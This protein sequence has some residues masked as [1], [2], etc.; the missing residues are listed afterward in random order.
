MLVVHLF[1]YNQ[2]FWSIVLC[3][4]HLGCAFF[5]Y[6]VIKPYFIF[7]TP[8]VPDAPKGKQGEQL[9]ILVFN[10]LLSNTN[11]EA[12]IELVSNDRPDTILL[13]EPGKAWDDNLSVVYREYPH[14]IKKIQ[15]DTYG[16]IF[17]SRIPFDESK[18]NH[19]VTERTPSTE[20]LIKMGDRRV[21][22]FG[23]HPEPPAPG[24]QKTSM[25]KDLEILLTAR[26]IISYDDRELDI[27]VGDLNDVGWSHISRKF[28]EVTDMQ[29]PR[30]GRGFYATFPT[31]LPFRIPIDH[32]FCSPG[33][34]L[35]ELKM[36]DNIGSD[37]LPFSATFSLSDQ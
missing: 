9:K 28:R 12:F 15:E 23:I 22:I 16:I 10:V 31:Y 36:H 25:P 5:I 2:G 32:V 18:I 4:I 34:D 7:S 1:F 14:I 6:K 21:R 11:Y 33:L 37:H 24:E 19:F 20:V 30:E 27:L 29:D 26:R 8:S 3:T 17:M 13:L 35:V